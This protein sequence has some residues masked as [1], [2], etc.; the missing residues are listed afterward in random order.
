MHGG[1][2]RGGVIEGNLRVLVGTYKILISTVGT[3]STAPCDGALVSTNGRQVDIA[4][5][6]KMHC[7]FRRRGKDGHMCGKGYVLCE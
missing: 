5:V 7:P 6:A 2:A 3:R 1:T 4:V